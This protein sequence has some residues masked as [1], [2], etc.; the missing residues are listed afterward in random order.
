MGRGGAIKHFLTFI[1]GVIM[2]STTTIPGISFGTMTML[3]NVYEKLLDSLSWGHIRKNLGFSAPLLSGAVVGIFSLSSLVTY[4]ISEHKMITYFC[5]IGLIVGCVP[6]IYRKAEI[7]K[8]KPAYVTAFAIALA[9]TIY[10]A[11]RHYS[12]MDNLTLEELGGASLSLGVWI[13][14]AGFICAV[15]MLI[16]GI[17]G[18]IIM[19]MLGTYTVSIE[20]VSKFYLPLVIPVGAGIGLGIV[21]GIR[22]IRK[23]LTHNRQVVY[24]AVLGLVIG[25]VFIIFPGFTPNGYG[26]IAII[27]GVAFVFVSYFFSRND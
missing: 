25:S 18:S 8:I 1:S 12:L 2:G 17:S 6:M 23:L 24:S 3:F 9:F 13:F 22:L 10:L 11:I 7:E 4:L 20:A 14:V 26:A 16:P 19:L 21:V 5:F 15:A 27:L